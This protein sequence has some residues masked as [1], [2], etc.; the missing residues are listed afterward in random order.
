MG[1]KRELR[2]VVDGWIRRVEFTVLN[3]VLCTST[4]IS[5]E[6]PDLRDTIYW[7]FQILQKQL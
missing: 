7:L 4:C 3:I 2:V 5:V 1:E 6:P